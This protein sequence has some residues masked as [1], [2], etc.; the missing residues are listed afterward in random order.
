MKENYIDAK[1]VYHNVENLTLAQIY[2]R[3]F[4]DGVN[5]MLSVE[6]ERREMIEEARKEAH[7][8]D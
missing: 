5:H 3:G 7:D 8:L 4:R 2:D 6:Q 1:G